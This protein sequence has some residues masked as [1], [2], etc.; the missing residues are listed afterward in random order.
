[1]RPVISATIFVQFLVVGLMMG[2]GALNLLF[3]DNFWQS[4]PT[5]V[6]FLAT[7]LETF[8]FCYACDLFVHDLKDLSY[9]IVASH[10]LDAAPSYK[11][12][13][14]IFLQYS[15]R[16][17]VF[18]AGGIFPISMNSNIKVAKIAFSVITLVQKMNLANRFVNNQ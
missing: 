12:T 17:I 15:Q 7:I 18:V 13:L 5:L 11:K 3:I 4:I 14:L 6:F 9:A 1:M 10:W 16:S 2:L 8:P